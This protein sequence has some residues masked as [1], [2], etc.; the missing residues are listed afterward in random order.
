VA[1]TPGGINIAPQLSNFQPVGVN[2]NPQGIAANPVLVNWGPV[3]VGDGALEADDTFVQPSNQAG[4]RQA[5][6]NDTFTQ[7]SNQAGVRQAGAGYMFNAHR[8]GQTGPS[9]TT[10]PQQPRRSVGP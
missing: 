6:T 3:G 1:I 2:I 10:Q 7:P 9:Q 4:V 5:G 8:P